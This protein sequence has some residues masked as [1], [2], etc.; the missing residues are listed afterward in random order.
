[1]NDKQR[2]G[3]L[4]WEPDSV[5]QEG[6]VIGQVQTA[7]GNHGRLYSVRLGRE[8]PRTP[9]A[10]TPYL[11]ARDLAAVRIVIDQIEDYLREKKTAQLRDRFHPKT[12][13]GQRGA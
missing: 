3:G 10:L 2:K 6:R 9:E 1:M 12:A 4:R 11:E 7:E 5:F 8:N 13:A